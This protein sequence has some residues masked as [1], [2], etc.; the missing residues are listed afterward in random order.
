MMSLF[1]GLRLMNASDISQ[2]AKTG[3]SDPVRDQSLGRSQRGVPVDTCYSSSTRTSGYTCPIIIFQIPLA[4]NQYAVFLVTIPGHPLEQM[5]LRSV[6]A[7]VRGSC[8]LC[9]Q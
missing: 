7:T 6:R 5:S 1:G 3:L 2:G 8:C 4:S 9:S